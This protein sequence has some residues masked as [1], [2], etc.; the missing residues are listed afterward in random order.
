MD[1]LKLAHKQLLSDSLLTFTRK[2]FYVNNRSEFKVGPHHVEICQVLEKC[3][4]GE[5]K[6]LMINIAP[7][8]GKSELVSRMFIAWCFGINP[9]CRFLHLSYSANLTTGNSTSIKDTINND[10]FQYAFPTKIRWNDNSKSHWSTEQGGELYA[11]STMGQITGFGA[12]NDKSKLNLDLDPYQKQF[13]PNGFGGAIVIDDPIKPDEALSDAMREAINLRFETT[14]RNRVNSR[15]VPIIIIMQRLHEH[16]LCGYLLEKESQN[17][18]VLSIPCIV[19]GEDGEQKALWPHKHTLEELEALRDINSVVFE[20]QYMQNPTPFEGLM[21]GFIRTYELL[22]IEKGIR[23]C[24]VD[25]ADTGSDF[26]CA[27]CYFETKSGMYITDVL[28]TK[29]PMEYTEIAT[30][31]MLVKNEVNIVKIESNNGGRGFCRNVE[32]NTRALQGKTSLSMRFISFTQSNN[33]QTR[34]YSHSAEV[35]NLIFFPIYWETKWPQFAMAIKGYRKEG[36]NA[37]DDAPDVL[38]GIVESFTHGQS[39]TTTKMKVTSFPLE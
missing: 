19:E 35:Q 21:Y 7:R 26:L 23:K 31:E 39:G 5:I 30:A 1:S 32:K 14:I 29:K 38:T 20:T 25:T 34:I 22:P 10:Y 6:N 27:V 33:K 4:R 8:Y 36:R 13:N 37:H 18:T 3:F 2:M 15:D 9:A 17:W 12:G 24:Y 11:T 16:D 28:Y